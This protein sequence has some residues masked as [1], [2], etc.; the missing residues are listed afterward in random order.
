MS[1]ENDNINNAAMQVATDLLTP[2]A[3]AEHLGIAHCT[4]AAWRQRGTGP[5][6]L[7]LGYRTVRYS[8]AE[9]DAWIASRNVTPRRGAAAGD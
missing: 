2:S 7:R 5:S 8:R 4:L 6:H 3:A 1:T 9:L